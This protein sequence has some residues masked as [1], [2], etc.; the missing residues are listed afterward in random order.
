MKCTAEIFSA[1]HWRGNRI[2]A[3]LLALLAPVLPVNAQ[4]GEEGE[5]LQ[6]E[7]IEVIGTTPVP[8]AGLPRTKIPYRIQSA[9]DKDLEQS[10]STDLTDYANRKIGGLIINEAQSNRLQ[11]DI[12]YRGF[13]ASPLLG[14]PQGLAVY[15]NSVRVNEAFGD[16]VNWELL[17]EAAIARIDLIGGANPLFGLNTLGGALALQ[18]K[19][20]FTHPGYGLE[21]RAGAFGSSLWQFHGGGTRDRL[22]AFVA[23]SFFDEDGWRDDSP[24]DARSLF[25]T[26]GYRSRDAQLDFNY[27]YGDSDLTGNGAVPPGLLRDGGRRAIFTAPDNT[28]NDMHLT[29]LEFGRWFNPQ[30]RLAGNVFYRANDTNSF[31][32]DASEF[33]ECNVDDPDTRMVDETE[34]L[35]EE[36]E[37]EPI[38]DQRENLIAEE[39]DDGT[40]RNAINNRSR[41]DQKSYGGTL[42]LTL[43]QPWGRFENQ[44]ILGGAYFEGITDFDSSVEIASLNAARSTVGTDLF[45]PREGVAVETETRTWS[46]YFT[47]T[48]SLTARWNLTLSGR[49]NHTWVELRDR[50]GSASYPLTVEDETSRLTGEHEY[51]RFNPAAGVSYEFRPNSHTYFNY[52]ESSRAPTPVELACADENDPCNLPNSFLADPPLEQVVTRGIEW[53]MRSERQW[54]ARA[55]RKGGADVRNELRSFFWDLGLFYSRNEDDILFQCTGGATCSEGFFANIGETQRVGAEFSAGGQRGYWH[56]GL[57]Y[58]YLHATYG[59]DFTA[60]SPGHPNTDEDDGNLQVSDGDRIPGIPLHSIKGL[61]EFAT[62]TRIKDSDTPPTMRIGAEWSYSSSR[63]LRG[64]ESNEDKPLGGYFLLNLYSEYRPLP[65]VGLFL[66]IDNVLDKEYETF[67]LYGEDDEVEEVLIGQFPGADN[68]GSRFVSPGAPRAGYLGIRISM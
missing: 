25:S 59:E 37:D 48:F 30:T 63:Y 9:S 4:E 43:A 5:I 31:N 51:G 62:P 60:S 65:W 33:E 16:T 66:R 11:P 14:L 24:S 41:R 47:D 38:E 35:C 49:Y 28:K 20:G 6:R 15:Q 19:N 42:E 29:N 32:G 39:N 10:L 64:D 12:L 18:T 57:N 53:G 13:T 7:T 52:S 44:L 56:W 34:F 55:E 23:G 46:G 36:G 22:G 50:G 27:T 8:G 61:L 45:V 2:A 58:T 67:G 17:P 40:E 54:L 3:F 26:F 68:Y 21:A 1:T